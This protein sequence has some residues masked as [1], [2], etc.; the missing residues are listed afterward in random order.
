MPTKDDSA[1]PKQIVKDIK[2][3]EALISSG[4]TLV[5]YTDFENQNFN[6]KNM[7]SSKIIPLLVINKWNIT[8]MHR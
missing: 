3:D 5:D 8:E 4:G 2:T 7:N 1:K 6:M